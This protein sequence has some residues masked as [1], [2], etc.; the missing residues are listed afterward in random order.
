MQIGDFSNNGVDTFDPLKQYLGIR[1]QQGVPLL[2]RDWNELEDIRRYFE[3]SLGQD[4]LGDGSP[5]TAGFQVVPPTFDAP[6]DVVISAGRLMAEGLNLLNLSDVLFSEQGARQTLPVSAEASALTL[7][8]QPGV[9]RI[10]QTQDPSLGN[11]Q[12]VNVETCLRDKL[13]WQ[14]A[15]IPTG[16]PLPDGAVALAQL[17][18]PANGGAVAASMITDLRRPLLNLAAT[19]DRVTAL[20]L[21]LSQLKQ[22]LNQAQLDIDAMKQD[23]GRLFWEVSIAQGGSQLLFGDA[24][25]LTV[26]VNDRLGNPIQGAAVALSSDWACVSP[27]L[28]VTDASGNA[29]AQLAAVSTDVFPTQSDLG[30]LQ[31]AVTRVQAASLPNGAIQHLGLRFAPQ[32][33]ALVSRYSPASALI[34]LAHDLPPSPIVAVPPSR[35][36]T[37][38]AHAREPGGTIV[39]GVGSTQ[40]TIG[41]WVRDW[42]LSRIFDVASGV[43]VA[44][45][46]GDFMR[47][48][49]SSGAFNVANMPA[50][51]L[52]LTLQ[53]IHD[54]THAVLRTRMFVDPAVTDDEVQQSGQL[55]RVVAE[56]ATAHVGAATN[57]AISNQLDQYAATPG[58]LAASAAGGART[59]LLQTSSQILAGFAQDARQRYNTARIGA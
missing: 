2:D 29:T 9:V 25:S 7:Y 11:T 10:D 17:N 16:N 49:I 48:G 40:V 52:Q 35:R 53:N 3:R 5:T 26:T 32:E 51:Q 31:Q 45:R 15:V 33:L 34:D 13:T 42:S 58:V 39:R 54:D 38:V 56:E 28:V 46:V 36:V 59:Q 50:G 47:Q 20:E 23:L 8:V 18:L 12:D 43:P 24:T 19:V 1:L 21:Q 27:A 37:V 4:Y 57:Q 22:G 30:V 44:A 14:A 6:N 55:A 41:L